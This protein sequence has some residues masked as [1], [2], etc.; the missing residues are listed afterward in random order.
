MKETWFQKGD[1]RKI[2]LKEQANIK[3]GRGK[4][5]KDQETK[6][7]NVFPKRGFMDK[8]QRKNGVLKGKTKG[9]PEKKTEQEEKKD[10]KD[11]PS[12]TQK[13]KKL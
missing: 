12:G 6:T 7:I 10:F 3:K 13:R 11:R 9:K 4:K 2:C 8:K 5:K 1:V